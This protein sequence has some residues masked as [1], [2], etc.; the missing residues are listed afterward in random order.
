MESGFLASPAQLAS[1]TTRQQSMGG[2]R[3]SAC[4]PEKLTIWLQ[5]PPFPIAPPSLKPAAIYH[6]A[7]AVVLVKTNVF[8]TVLLSEVET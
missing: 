6:W 8:V 7:R 1:I 4:Y 3:S 2:G 5:S